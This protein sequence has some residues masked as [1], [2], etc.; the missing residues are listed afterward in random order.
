MW[1]IP[2]DHKTPPA[3]AQTATAAV[4]DVCSTRGSTPE[5]PRTTQD[6]PVMGRSAAEKLG[7]AA[8]VPMPL[9]LHCVGGTGSDSA[10]TTPRGTRT[11][12][13]GGEWQGW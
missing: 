13:T 4:A 11:S 2:G 9:G 5:T 10:P 6:I 12:C 7:G 3:S 1:G 8:S